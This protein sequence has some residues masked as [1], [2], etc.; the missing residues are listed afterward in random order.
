MPCSRSFLL[1]LSTTLVVSAAVADVVPASEAGRHVGTHGTVEGDVA[2]V[3]VDASGVVL[4]FSVAEGPGFRAVLVRSLV[5]SLPR[6]PSQVYAGK[7]VRITGL[8]Q[9]FAGRP[10]M[11]LESASQIEVVDVAGA[12]SPATTTTTRTIAPTTVPAATLPPAT[13]PAPAAAVSGSARPA[14]STVPAPPTTSTLPPAPAEVLPGLRERLAADA[15]RRARERWATAA[16]A[17]RTATGALDRC[18]GESPYRCRAATAAVAPR[19]ADLEWAEQEVA[20]R[21]P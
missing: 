14:A 2:T 9:R 1:A 5:S 18:L 3:T 7:R 12:P 19:L 8:I 11:I 6:D 20:E 10:E 16:A 17:A 21:C 15:C 4:S 13:T